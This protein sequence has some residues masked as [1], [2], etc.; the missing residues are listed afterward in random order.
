MAVTPKMDQDGQT[1]RKPSRLT[2][3][4]SKTVPRCF[5]HLLDV[6]KGA[7]RTQNSPETAYEAPKSTQ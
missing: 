7:K 6:D 1:P 2:N 3:M 4:A 5:D